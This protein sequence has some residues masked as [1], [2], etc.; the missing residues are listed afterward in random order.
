MKIFLP[1]FILLITA[2]YAKAKN[3]SERTELFRLLS[4]RKQ[5]FDIY[6][7][8][9]NQ[10]SGFFG[11]TSKKDLRDSQEK[12]LAVIEADNKIMSALNRTLDFR[13]F[14]KQTM[15]YDVSSYEN[16]IRS[17]TVLN[18][19]LNKQYLNCSNENKRLNS[20][21]KRHHLYF[22]ALITILIVSFVIWAKKKFF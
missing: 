18:D 1:L 7:A 22:A 9:L 11:N 5:L 17:I 6:T 2:F 19:T 16:R 8:S 21:L 20:V 4:E 15:S 14:E 13:N 3:D 10:K 12:L